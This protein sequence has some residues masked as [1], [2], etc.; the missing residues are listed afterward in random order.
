VIR[1][2]A[3][4][5]A[6]QPWFALLLAVAFLARALIPVGFMPAPQGLVMCSAVVAGEATSSPVAPLRSLPGLGSTGTEAQ[7]H[8]TCQY[9]LSL[10]TLA[11]TTRTPT[12]LLAWQIAERQWSFERLP[13]AAFALLRKQ[14]PRGPPAQA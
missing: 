13:L 6:R 7:S 1:R 2:S 5:L 10:A 4:N 3:Q 14:L 11:D 12:L 9:A 8:D